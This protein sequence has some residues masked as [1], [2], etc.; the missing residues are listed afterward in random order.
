MRNTASAAHHAARGLG[1][2]ATQWHLADDHPSGMVH[3][4]VAV[5][6]MPV[7]LQHMYTWWGVR[8]HG[9]GGGEDSAV[10]V[11]LM[12]AGAPRRFGVGICADPCR[13]VS[14]SVKSE[15]PRVHQWFCR[16]HTQWLMQPELQRYTRRSAQMLSGSTTLVL[17]VAVR[18]FGTTRA[19]QWRVCVWPLRTAVECWRR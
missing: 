10:T 14:C 18:G 4:R 12:A 2:V 16:G 3:T 1:S 19:P 9:A 6:L 8:W 11:P 15:P 7:L 17:S 5:L 13:S